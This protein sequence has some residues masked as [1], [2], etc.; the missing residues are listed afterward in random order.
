MTKKPP[1]HLIV[2]GPDWTVLLK[3]AKYNIVISTSS[4]INHTLKATGIWRQN[5]VCSLLPFSQ[6]SVEAL[7]GWLWCL[8][9]GFIDPTQTGA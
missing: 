9:G 1:N 4:I 2:K 6:D 7:E 8:L 5:S 3:I